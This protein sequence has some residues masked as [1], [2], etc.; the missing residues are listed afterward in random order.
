MKNRFTLIELLIVVAIIG[1]L[2]S[3]LLPSLGRARYT[4]KLAVCKSNQ[5][6]IG[7]ILFLI[8]KENNGRHWQRSGINKPTEI[9]YQGNDHRDSIEE[10][11]ATSEVLND[12]FCKK[13]DIFNSTGKTVIEMSYTIFAGVAFSGGKSL[14]HLS[15]NEFSFNGDSFDILAADYEHSVNPHG[16]EMSHP[17]R[18]NTAKLQYAGEDHATHLLSRFSIKAYSKYDRNF[19]RQDGSVFGL[20]TSMNDNRLKKIP[21]FLNGGAYPSWSNSLP[22]K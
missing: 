14:S 18:G 22:S 1:I 3:L 6:Q 13:I 20:K 11:G 8:A 12:P 9:L 21:I 10:F 15:K 5:S 17:N 2:V 4:S 19:L 16:I 7:K